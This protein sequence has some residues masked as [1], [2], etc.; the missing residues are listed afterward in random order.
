MFMEDLW[1]RQS[2]HAWV[3]FLGIKNV[4]SDKSETNYRGKCL[5]WPVT[6]YGGGKPGHH[7]LSSC[8]KV[9]QDIFEVWQTNQR[10]PST[11]STVLVLWIICHALVQVWDPLAS[12]PQMQHLILSTSHLCDGKKSLG[13]HCCSVLP[14]TC[15]GIK[16]LTKYLWI[17]SSSQPLWLSRDWRK[18]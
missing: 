10:A 18:S 5:G 13:L 12:S 3:L 14:L 1:L 11:L 16:P 6:S 17:L 2:V 4:Y 9:T 15:S 7:F 8:S